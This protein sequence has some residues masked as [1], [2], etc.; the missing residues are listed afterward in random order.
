MIW[1]GYDADACEANAEAIRDLVYEGTG[2]IPIVHEHTDGTT[3]RLLTDHTGR[4][5]ASFTDLPGMDSMFTAFT[6]APRLLAWMRGSDIRSQNHWHQVMNER[7]SLH[8]DN[9]R[10]WASIEACEHDHVDAYAPEDDQGDG[11]ASTGAT[12]T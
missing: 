11:L 10:L 3:I 9:A 5:V 7:D 2:L 4:V 8:V 1:E 12:T 6:D